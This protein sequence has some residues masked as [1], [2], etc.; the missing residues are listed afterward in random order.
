MSVSAISLILSMGQGNALYW[1]TMQ[2]DNCVLKANGVII[3][4]SAP[5]NTVASGYPIAASQLKSTTTFE[6]EP[7]KGSVRGASKQWSTFAK[8]L[9]LR[10][11]FSGMVGWGAVTVD[12]TGKNAYVCNSSARTL[13]IVPLA[14][15]MS[16]MSIPVGLGA[17][18]V[19]LGDD[20]TVAVVS[21]AFDDSISIIDLTSHKITSTI[22]GIKSP[23]G[24][25]ILGNTA[26]IASPQKSDSK[27]MT[28]NIET[29]ELSE[30]FAVKGQPFD[31][32]VTP[33]GRTIY[34]ANYSSTSIDV[35]DVDSASMT[36]SIDVKTPPTTVAVSG[37]GASVYAGTQ[38]GTD[39][40]VLNSHSSPPDVTAVVSALSRPAN[41]GV[42]GSGQFMVTIGPSGFFVFE[43]SV[44]DLPNA[45]V[46][47]K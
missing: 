42:S 39:I 31:V 26:F 37:N 15:G 9:F 10:R 6:L 38:T 27:I 14:T 20:D 21:N 11:S 23:A 2:S 29:G 41:I 47:S 7:V 36:H 12:R 16:T 34:V 19:S 8:Q 40:Y 5:A 4:P 22:S 32:A 13:E 33:D 25:A 17:R 28:V 18:G 45:E 30:L 1:S 43:L 24:S 44:P 46:S 3:D 35:Y